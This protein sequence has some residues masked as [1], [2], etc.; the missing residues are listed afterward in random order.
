MADIWSMLRELSMG[1][2]SQMSAITAT[3]SSVARRINQVETSQRPTT[4]TAGSDSPQLDTSPRPESLHST[5]PRLS[6]SWAD[7]ESAQHLPLSRS[8]ADRDSE[9][10]LTFDPNDAFIWPDDDLEL[11]NTGDEQG[12]QLNFTFFI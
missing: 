9:E 6:R 3:V 12:C 2:S 10:Q 4:P 8:W 5:C 11:D 7:R 1:L